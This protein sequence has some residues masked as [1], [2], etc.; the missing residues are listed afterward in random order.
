MWGFPL[1]SCLIAGRFF[2]RER[3]HSLAVGYTRASYRREVLLV[4]RAL[5]REVKRYARRG[6]FSVTF[7]QTHLLSGRARFH[8]YRFFTRKH[9][10]F[11][12]SWCVWQ[13]SDFAVKTIVSHCP[14]S[15]FTEKAQLVLKW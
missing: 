6:E 15:S 4:Y 13:Y 11:A 12:I 14:Y 5:Q 1:F 2:N 3:L 8:A 10:D 7:I 9:P